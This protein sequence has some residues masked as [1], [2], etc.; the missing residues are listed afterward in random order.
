MLK[1]TPAKSLYRKL[2]KIFPKTNGQLF[3]KHFQELWFL[4]LRITIVKSATKLSGSSC[5]KVFYKKGLLKVLE[6][7]KNDFFTEHF[8][9]LLL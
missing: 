2:F 5:S 9:W 7:F 8:Q 1:L 6:V 4:F 3:S